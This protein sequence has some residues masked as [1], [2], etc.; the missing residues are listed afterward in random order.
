MLLRVAVLTLLTEV[1]AGRASCWPPTTSST[2]IA[3]PSMCWACD[4]S[5][6]R[7]SRAGPAGVRGQTPPNGV[8]ADLPTLLLAPLT[9]QAAAERGARPAAR[10]RRAAPGSICCGQPAEMRWPSSNC[11]ARSQRAARE[12]CPAA[13]CRRRSVSRRCTPAGLRGLPEMTRRLIL[14]AAASENKTSPR[15]RPPPAP[16]GSRGVGP[17]RGGRS[18]DRRGR[19]IGLPASAGARRSL[20]REPRLISAAGRRDLA[21]ALTA[22]PARR[23]WH[24]AAA[25]VGYDESVA[26]ALEDTPD[27]S[28][29]AAAFFAAAQA[30]KRVRRVQP[31]G[32]GP[33]SPVRQGGEGRPRTPATPRGCVSCMTRS[34]R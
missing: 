20:S 34:L 33:G 14:Y 27:S 1:S 21:A 6:H 22:D 26:A 16:A 19:A 4:P 32:R 15:S 17:G 2:S 25:C 8:A 18:G 7:G 12:H 5:Y 11:A 24:L 3:T 23:A 29:G 31:H 10:T 30:L 9:E 13:G 28:N